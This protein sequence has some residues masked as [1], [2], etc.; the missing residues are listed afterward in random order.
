MEKEEIL[1]ENRKVR[2]IE[3][4]PLLFGQRFSTHGYKYIFD[5]W[6]KIKI[7]YVR[8]CFRYKQRWLTGG[9]FVSKV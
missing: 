8:L 1:E 9:R 2:E 6:H 3:A 5:I 4:V 7:I